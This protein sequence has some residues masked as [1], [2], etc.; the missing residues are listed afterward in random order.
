MKVILID[1][2]Q[3]MHLILRK[4]LEKIPEV[5]VAGAFTNTKSAVA[6]LNEHKDVGL[7]FVD[8]SL[9]GENG[10]EFAAKMEAWGSPVQLVFVTSHKEYALD[11]Y[12]LYV[13]DY[14][15]KPV[16][17]ERLQRTVHRALAND[18]ASRLL[19]RP[20]SAIQDAG[21]TVVTAFGDVVVSNEAGRIKWISRKC[22]E[23]FAYLLLYHG[24]R[25]PRSRLIADIFMGM[26]KGHAEKYLNTTVHQLRKSLEP[27]GMRDVVRSENDGYALELT[28]PSIDY[29]E[30]EKQVK[31]L[32][33]IEAGDVEL[34][35]QIERSYIGDLF[36]DKAY[37]WAIHE[38]ERYAEMYVSFAKRLAEALLAVQDTSAASKLLMKLK[39]R[40][41][42]DESVTRLWMS[43][44]ERMG[45]KKGLTMIYTDYVRLL[46][47]ELGIRPSDDLVRHYDSL[48]GRFAN[49]K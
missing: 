45:D 6:F 26:E 32:Q 7:A 30:F 12:E 38:T 17:Q 8:I 31:Q 49:K 39:Q 11:A 21:K 25:I 29:A 47:R 18:R 27:L 4:M 33:T 36:G 2:E 24:R 15:V 42:L 37:V 44:H 9:A 46:N 5:Q 19:S 43:L 1:D 16:V 3:A 48:I 34:A 10:L 23:L 13:L 41:P 14:L 40:N 20:A 22:A 28:N 35:R